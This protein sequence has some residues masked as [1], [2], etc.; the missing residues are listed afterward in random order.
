MALEDD[1]ENGSPNLANMSPEQFR[2]YEKETRPKTVAVGR[3]QCHA[4]IGGDYCRKK[5]LKDNIYCDKCSR[6]L[7]GVYDKPSAKIV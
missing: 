6:R 4:L 7:E 2:I 3:T 5:T 1:A